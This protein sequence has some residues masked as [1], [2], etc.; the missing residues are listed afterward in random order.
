MRMRAS[1]NISDRATPYFCKTLIMLVHVKTNES[2]THGAAASPS[3]DLSQTAGSNDSGREGL[4]YLEKRQK[5]SPLLRC[6]LS[7]R[8]S[9]SLTSLQ[10]YVSKWP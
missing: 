2:N 7:F 4:I 3:L 10:Y 5:T 6:S 1:M 8:T 9:P